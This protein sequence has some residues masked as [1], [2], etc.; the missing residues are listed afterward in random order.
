MSYTDG[1]NGDWTG[2]YGSTTTP[3]AG[4]PTFTTYVD[5]PNGG[6][7][8]AGN[9][10]T[11]L[12]IGDEINNFFASIFSALG[13]IGSGVQNGVQT[14]YNDAKDGANNAASAVNKDILILGAGALFVFYLVN[15]KR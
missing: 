10:S 14:V 4:G 8:I 9:G 7:P 11:A 13:N 6:P 12:T 15:K 3:P 5:N 2:S 1:G